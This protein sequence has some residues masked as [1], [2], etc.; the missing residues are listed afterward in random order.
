M[1]DAHLR[2]RGALRR[3]V[4]ALGAA[5]L[6]TAGLGALP[7]A[8]VVGDD[9]TVTVDVLGINDFHGRISRTLDDDGVV[10]QAGAVALAGAV[11]A[12]R[13]ENEDT[14]FVS[15]GDNI[16]ASTFTSMVANDQPTLDVLKAMGLDAS[17]VGNHELD[18]G[19]DALN[20]R[21]AGDPDLFPYLAANVSGASDYEDYV[22]VETP[23]GVSVGLVGVVTPTVPSLVTPAGI[24]GLDFAGMSESANAVAAQLSDG[25]DGNG[26]ADVVVVLAHD[27]ASGG[28]LADATDDSPFGELVTQA[29]ADIDVIFSGHTH[30]AYA[31]VLERDGGDLAVVQAGSFG[32]LL[33][34][35]SLTYDPDADA[36]TGVTT[37]LVDL[38]GDVPL[39]EG[40]VADIVAAAEAEAEVLGAVVL[41]EI[42]GDLNRA[43][44]GDGSE[45][46]GG[47]STLGNLIAD[48]QLWATAD[49]GADLAIMNPGGI[50][51][52]LAFA[53]EAGSETNVDGAVTYEE[54]ATVQPFANTLVTMELT[55]AQVMSILEEQWQP[56]GAS[57]PF[58]KLGVSS[59]LTYLYDPQA[60]RGERI[61]HAYLDGEVLDPEATY[62]VTTNSFLASGG[63]NFSTFAEG[64]GVA[65][66]GRVDLQAFVDY[67]AEAAEAGTPVAPDHVQRAIGVSWVSDPNAVYA[68]GDEVA[69]DLSSLAFSTS[70]PKPAELRLV[71]GDVEVGTAAVD[72]SPVDGTDEG[73]RAQVRVTVPELAGLIEPEPVQL[74][75]YDDVNGYYVWVDVLVGPQETA[76]PSPTPEPTTTVPAPVATTPDDGGALPSTGAATHGPLLAALVMA[77]IGALLVA[78]VR[79]WDALAE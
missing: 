56:E 69:V 61:T 3:P 67:L 33:G 50:R 14:V 64:T 11:A 51:A 26:E 24:E 41:G 76:V 47:E 66:S 17:A 49:L 36:V 29:S 71:L 15:A 53:G 8:A 13:A 27:G 44:Q 55:G 22:V 20:A 21:I 1:P 46:R 54:A 35:I 68:P 43:R 79:R 42:S 31:H 34:R 30:T 10:T 6:L 48:V 75:A 18:Q 78:A 4:A 52:D 62:T 57:R 38:T 73:G 65:D 7:A 25:D 40:E 45:N 28:E 12:A 77:L 2:P 70:E 74:K 59:G 5:G 9:G 63:D 16:G 39:D 37:E 23:S 72:A 19:Q 32:E 60:G 58:L